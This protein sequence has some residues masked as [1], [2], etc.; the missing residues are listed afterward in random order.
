MG[1][2]NSGRPGGNPDIKNFGFKTERE[3]PLLEKLQL[4]I[5]AS[6]KEEIKS[7][8]NWQELVRLAIAKELSK[9]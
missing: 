3:E 2:K 7:K 6:M 1:N 8:D 4:R 9:A 5:S